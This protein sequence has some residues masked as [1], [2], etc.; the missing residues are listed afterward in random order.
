[1]SPDDRRGYA[2]ESSR[3]GLLGEWEEEDDDCND[4]PRLPASIRKLSRQSRRVGAIVGVLL[5]LVTA[6]A[7]LG[8]L[9]ADPSLF[10]YTPAATVSHTH[11]AVASAHLSSSDGADSRLISPSAIVAHNPSPPPASTAEQHRPAAFMSLFHNTLLPDLSLADQPYPVATTRLPGGE[12]PGLSVYYCMSAQWFQYILDDVLP[13]VFHNY[14]RVDRWNEN[15]TN[16]W[17]LQA[18]APDDR[19]VPEMMNRALGQRRIYITGEPGS[20]D[21]DLFDMDA[22]LDTKTSPFSH[23]P[24]TNFVY[25]PNVYAAHYD[26]IMAGQ[27]T[28]ESQPELPW[29][30]SLIKP[31]H[32]S[33][34]TGY[35]KRRFMAY[36]QA[37]C[38]PWRDELFDLISAYRS[39]DGIGACRH[40]HNVPPVT[41]P[42]GS[43]DKWWHAVS[44]YRRYKFVLVLES[45][46]ID[47]Y[48]TEK[49]L[50]PMLAGAVPVYIGSADIGDHF[51]ERAFINVGRYSS[52]SRVMERIIYLD[53]N[54]TAYA[55]LLDQPWLKDNRPTSWMPHNSTQSYLHQQL[56]ALRDVLLHPN[57]TNRMAEGLP[58]WAR[59]EQGWK[60][61]DVEYLRG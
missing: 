45:H 17:S 40:N 38:V 49:I 4:L 27:P 26:F 2:V 43:L 3:D 15:T 30:M 51:N 21:G 61:A 35:R 42:E 54:H 60:G 10:P 32:Y 16:L 59:T 20:S 19:P 18:F 55:E 6:S 11:A 39:V 50:G 1:M 58:Q 53:R 13:A 56:A 24:G 9:S 34:L 23:P 37:H 41:G 28:D 29:D 22:V 57:Y 12:L 14:T 7:W 33:S 44:I 5:L 25:L 47:G 8:R 48:I 36:M 46:L 31:P 52:L